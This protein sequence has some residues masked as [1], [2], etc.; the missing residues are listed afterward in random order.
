MA[1]SATKKVAKKK[2]A[3]DEYVQASRSATAATTTAVPQSK[4]KTTQITKAKSTT[5][6]QNQ[7]AQATT[8]TRGLAFPSNHFSSVQSGSKSTGS[9][10]FGST[11]LLQ[12]LNSFPFASSSRN[13]VLTRTA[14]QDS[15]IGIPQTAS[16]PQL[17]SQRTQ[18]TRSEPRINITAGAVRNQV[19]SSASSVRN[20]TQS[21]LQ[22]TRPTERQ[23][24]GAI[25]S[26]ND[27]LEFASQLE[28]ELEDRYGSIDYAQYIPEYRNLLKSIHHEQV[29][30]Q[31]Q[32][33]FIE[34]N[35]RS[36]PL[37]GWIEATYTS[38]EHQYYEDLL[39]NVRN[40]LETYNDLCN[41]MP[42]LSVLYDYYRKINFCETI[43]ERPIDTSGAEY[44]DATLEQVI[45]GNYT[46]KVTG[47]GTGAQIALGLL[48][49]DLPAD[50]RDV[51]YDWTHLKDT[52]VWQTALDTFAFLPLVGSLKYVDEIA[53]VAKHSDEAADALATAARHADDLT[54]AGKA[55]ENAI[56]SSNKLDYNAISRA[57]NNSSLRPPALMDELAES[58]VKYSPDDVVM[59]TKGSEGLM[60][61]E[62]GNDSSGWRHIWQ[63]HGDQLL[64]CGI[65]ESNI[66]HFLHEVI[67]LGPLSPPIKDARGC[68]VFYEF[69]NQR[70]L[71]VYGTNGY[72]VSFYPYS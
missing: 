10:R 34:N 38:V 15:I 27:H 49:L 68:H 20:A 16:A 6:S 67:Q 19:N 21:L 51:S 32:R 30:Y 25:K 22:E 45:K 13:S 36:I 24:E 53:D 64:K 9:N 37:S 69:N 42:E 50:I 11:S 58:G 12:P 28:A 57:Q 56:D 46:D 59:V 52:P 7:S 31:K 43:L 71:L 61:L 54:D 17:P 8:K 72:I 26:G 18:S 65:P 66:P 5:A 48:N 70:Y 55:A 40:E 2:K 29:Q 33:E 3:E 14:A 63:R 44:M 41:G 4:Q 35:Y 62:T 47:L 39:Q 23:F 1:V 60:W